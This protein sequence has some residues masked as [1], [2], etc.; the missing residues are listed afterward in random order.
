MGHMVRQIHS[1]SLDDITV[2]YGTGIMKNVTVT[3]DDVFIITDDSRNAGLRMN[4]KLN[5]SACE[6]MLG[7]RDRQKR[8]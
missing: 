3:E 2:E 8:E 1:L 5:Q 6:N 4:V 7:G